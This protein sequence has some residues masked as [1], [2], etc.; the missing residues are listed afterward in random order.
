MFHVRIYISSALKKI[1]GVLSREATA[2][3]AILKLLKQ[4]DVDGIP[5]S[6]LVRLTGYSRQA[7]SQALSMLEGRGVVRRLRVNGELR[8]W[9]SNRLP[10]GEVKAFRLG[11]IKALEYPFVVPLKRRLRDEG[12][13]LDVK[14]YPSG[15]EVLKDLLRGRLEAALAP[16]TTQLLYY[17]L[18]MGSL[19]LLAVAARGGGGLLSR[20]SRVTQGVKVASTA[21]SSM[22]AYSLTS[23]KRLGIEEAEVSMSYKPS[24]NDICEALNRGLVEAA[25]IWEPYATMLEEHGFKRLID[26]LTDL[27][28]PI[29][30]VLSVRS[31]LSEDL[32]LKVLKCYLNSHIDFKASKDQYLTGYASLLDLPRRLL[33]RALKALRFDPH[34]EFSEAYRTLKA[35]NLGS[36]TPAL[37]L[38][39]SAIVN[40]L[41]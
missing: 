27:D 18:S 31:S 40:G 24:A 33:T 17:E 11:L 38:A 29:C 34:L 8:V 9:L 10:Q 16:L 13:A 39:K 37:R 7:I 22:E 26:Y 41:L 20:A 6:D 5:Q 3:E 35:L 21:L 30:C 15:L 28:E 14:V 19:E 2:I 4:V 32:K 23:L 12:L 25:S 36:L 1:K